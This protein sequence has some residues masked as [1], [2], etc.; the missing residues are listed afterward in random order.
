MPKFAFLLFCWL[1]VEV[2]QGCRDSKVWL[3]EEFY[4]TGDYEREASANG[5]GC[6]YCTNVIMNV[7]H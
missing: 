5:D 3:S 6:M 2:I 7:C 1:N 4:K